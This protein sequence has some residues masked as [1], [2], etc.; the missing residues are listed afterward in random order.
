MKNHDR[1]T[2]HVELATVNT[3]VARALLGRT[4][5]ISSLH[6][7]IDTGDGTTITVALDGNTVSAD[8]KKTVNRRLFLAAQPELDQTGHPEK[9]N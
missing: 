2:L 4:A 5:C 1:P 9:P 3:A 7:C 8:F 6:V